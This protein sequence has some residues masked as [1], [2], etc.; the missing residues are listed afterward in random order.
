MPVS[1]KRITRKTRDFTKVTFEVPEYFEGTFEVPDFNRLNVEELSR[2][3]DNDLR[4]IAD[5]F[6][7]TGCVDE[8]D[9]VLEMEIDEI[10]TF[11]DAWQKASGVDLPK[12]KG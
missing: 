1:K 10:Q 11:M 3:T 4:A 8:A 2:V 12:S 5:L 7:R 6:R 9:A